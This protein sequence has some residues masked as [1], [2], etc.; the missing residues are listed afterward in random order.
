MVG[1]LLVCC[2]R[3][4][5]GQRNLQATSIIPYSLPWNH[6]ASLWEGTCRNQDPPPQSGSMD[7]R[8]QQSRLAPIRE[9]AF[10]SSTRIRLTEGADHNLTEEEEA[11]VAQTSELLN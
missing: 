7:G 1:L 10:I 3:E 2:E 9:V 4:T 6:R 11:E 5:E 8:V